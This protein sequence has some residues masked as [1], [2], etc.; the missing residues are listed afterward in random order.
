M[1]RILI[2]YFLIFSFTV[3]S[4]STPYWLQSAGSPNVDE[5]LA[6]AK[7]N[8]NNIITAGYFT[9]TI[10]F[11]N[12][13]T[14]TSASP[15]VSDV[16]IQ[17]T[18]PNGQVVWKI[19]A[20]GMGSD[21][22]TGVAC[23]GSGNIY[24]TGFYYGTAQFGSFILNSVNN[25][26]DIFIAKLNS[27]G[28]FQWAV[29]AGGTLAE[30]PYAITVDN[31]GNVIVT[32]EF[33]GKATFGGISII[34]MLN[35]ANNSSF[36][37]FTAKYDNN[38]NFLWVRQGAAK[39]DDR[40]LDVG[41]DASGN[42]YVCGQF[43][44]T[45]TFNSVHNNQIAN[46]VFIIKYSPGGN[47]M[48]FR[49]AGATNS[50]AYG[51]TVDSNNDL[52]VTGDY[53][54]NMIFYGT[55]NNFLFG[56]YTNRIFLAKYNSAGTY[57]WGKEDASNSYVSSKDVA[58]DPN[59]NPCIYG[60][61]DCRMDEYSVLAGGTGMFNS[62]GYHDLFITQYDKNGGR[63]WARNFGGAKND[64]AHGIV[65]TNNTIPY[66][67]GSYEHKLFV[68]SSLYPFGR[69]NA[70]YFVGNNNVSLF[71]SNCGNISNAYYGILS[72]GF[73]DC[74]IMHGVDNS[75][76]YYDY[77]YRPNGGCSKN[78]V[79]GCI[80]DY[81]YNCQDTLYLCRPDLIIAN[82]YAG[83]TN[84]VGPF[85]H[86]KWNTG[87]TLVRHKITGSGNYSCV[88][89]TY[90]GCFTS[91]DTVYA[92]IN[93]KPGPPTITDSY[94]VNVNQLPLTHSLNICGSTVTL[95]GG[96]LQGCSY[97]WTS[98]TGGG[99]V[100]VSGTSCV[101]NKT[102]TFYFWLTNSYGCKE[103]NRIFVKIDTLEQVV[104]KTNMPDSFRVCLGDCFDYFI[105][106]SIS[107]PTGIPY[108]CFSS[109]TNVVP[110]SS[111]VSGHPY[112]VWNNLSLRIC[113][114]ST[115]WINLHTKYV[116]SGSCGRDSVYF[117]K[118]I[119][120]MVNPKPY[121]NVNVSGS[122]FICPGD[123][124][125]LV[126]IFTIIPSSNV[127]YTISP[128]DSIWANAQGYYYIGIN[129]KDTVTGCA[130]N[131]MNYLYVNTKLDP[132]VYTNPADGLICPGDSVKLT[133]SWPGAIS[134]E[135]HGP[136]GILP[137]NAISV[138]DSI[139]GFYYCVATDNNGCRLTSNTVEIKKYNT[140]YLIALPG[141]VVCPGQPL[142]IHVIS[143]D[144]SLIQWLPP[145]SGG[146][147]IRNVTTSGTYS[148]Q[149]TMCGIT[150]LCQITVTVA[151]PVSQITAIGSLTIC[152]GDSVILTGNA[153]M[154]SYMWL[155]G[156]IYSDTIRAYTSGTYV[157][158]I[159][160]I[161]GCQATDSVSVLYNPNAPPH[162]TTTNDSICTGS[163]ANLSASTGGNYAVEWYTQAYSGPVVNTGSS[164][165][166]PGLNQNTTY[167]VS[168]KDS[169]GCHSVR[170][171]ANVYIIQTSFLPPIVGDSL[172][173]AGDTL[174]LFTNPLSGAIYNW[175]GP[176]S[177]SSSADSIMIF[178]LDSASQGTYTL[179]VSG[180][181]CTSP[182]NTFYVGVI[183]VHQPSAVTTD[184]IC[185]G[186]TIALLALSQDTGVSY[187]WSGPLGFSCTNQVC[188]L[189]SADSSNSGNYYLQ[190]TIGNC[191]SKFDTLRVFVKPT[192]HPHITSISNG[193]C[194]GDSANLFSSTIPGASTDW[195]GPFGFS[196]AIPDPVI[197]NLNAN[198]VGYYYLSSTINGCSGTD[199]VF[200]YYH[201]LPNF[202]LGN[203]TTICASMPITL[204]PGIF[205]S[206]N[207]SNGSLDTTYTVYNTGPVSVTVTNQYGCKYSDTINVFVAQC[208]LNKPNVFTPN[209]D[210]INDVF[211]FNFDHYEDL[212]FII[213]DRWGVKMFE[214]SEGKNGWD[215][216]NMYTGKHVTD[217]TY[218]YI[219]TAKNMLGKELSDKGFI[220]VFK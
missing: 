77:Y 29:S 91:E 60:E 26:Q 165:I 168:V 3:F 70:N 198:S 107:N 33:Q 44:D 187:S 100:S 178:P 114:S 177:F 123:S 99:I 65:F 75:C 78:F 109:L 124:T 212:K 139:P 188:T 83:D 85:Y 186:E 117:D 163:A 118:M 131:G 92:K 50:I 184:S 87:D 164:Y 156:N 199:S 211:Y 66:V 46:A 133:C 61:F 219:V 151:N 63:T 59:E 37:I 181:G 55:P 1:K 216:M 41:T 76:P 182:Q 56:S 208:F 175:S 69:Y 53:T 94:S 116:F 104:P 115:G 11:P 58:L 95:T 90:D 48:W 162:P 148:C 122:N 194:Y 154:A 159:T 113:P 62:I 166:T 45:I 206:Y 176:D 180:Y 218:Y 24:I 13:T 214:N 30:D 39:Y 23:D 138:Y 121:V 209:G 80:D 202:N 128:N 160:D 217:G 43:S 158:V 10:T 210:G 203:D 108:S 220:Q 144:T 22:A 167:Y 34:S 71:N 57:L 81:S 6:I 102:D 213:Y 17:K 4:Q 51:L 35:P 88:M 189:N 5:N 79:G 38:G 205:N 54:G 67:C 170:E 183:T 40:G 169:V 31:T 190:T 171:P 25:T 132:H 9:N 142:S 36:D 152:P 134:W 157:L 192:P 201:P 21:R 106:D 47:E 149:V 2:T 125:L 172:L 150:T 15:G 73:S 143:N 64:L 84:S 155:P 179:V 74:F 97:A 98:Y 18:D 136:A 135:W 185:E 137:V 197:I 93:P 103:L 119:Y 101:V 96:N 204:D 195:T 215:G 207:W 161:N 191:K 112:C 120:V 173:C 52:Y 20:G 196:S 127:S 126:A 140:P 16:L 130:G 147:T 193:Y 28:V 42:V 32:G 19:K 27:S 82:V 146:G 129:A 105:Y 72:Y 12:N 86:Y 7:D 110:S 89:T 49:K 153:G 200:I 14:L 174:H 141:T 68:N 111:A 145:F 8:N